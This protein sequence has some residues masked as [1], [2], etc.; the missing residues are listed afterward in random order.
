[1]LQVDPV[2][3]LY[4]GSEVAPLKFDVIRTP[5]PS[6]LK[7][8]SISRLVDPRK[9]RPFA[10]DSFLSRFT[11]TPKPLKSLIQSRI[12][13]IEYAVRHKE[14]KKLSGQPQRAALEFVPLENPCVHGVG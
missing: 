6:S 7:R 9:A 14:A 2:D 4:E 3:N 13:A 11:P 1:M 12:P 8:R 5:E 10:A